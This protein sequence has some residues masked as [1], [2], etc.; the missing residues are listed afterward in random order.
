MGPPDPFP[1]LRAAKLNFPPPDHPPPAEPSATVLARIQAAKENAKQREAVPSTSGIRLDL[2]TAGQPLN[3]SDFCFGRGTS[4]F[5][6][7][8]QRGN[9]WAAEIRSEGAN[10]Y[11]GRFEEQEEAARAYD[12]AA[13]HV[14]KE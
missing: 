3:L 11:L 1:P 7:V 4:K 14:H 10:V 6:G 9:K 2:N 12:S 8:V 13:F 5:R